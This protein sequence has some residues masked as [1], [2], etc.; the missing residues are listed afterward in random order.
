M[1]SEQYENLIA[2]MKEA[3]K[4]YANNDNY[5]SRGALYSLI[6]MD[7][8]SQARFTLQ[9]VQET[10]EENQKMMNDYNKVI[11]ET[12]DA[13]ENHPFDIR[14]IKAEIDALNNIGNE[15]HD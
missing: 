9:Q 1:N 13:I 6:D 4:F 11:S 14:N 7:C 3:L 2:L 5:R 12:I 8:G 10:L 15:G